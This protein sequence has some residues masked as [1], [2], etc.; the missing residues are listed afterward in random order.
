MHL[1][2]TIEDLLRNPECPNGILLDAISDLVP[3]WPEEENPMATVF[4]VMGGTGEY[5]DHRSWEVA[6]FLDEAKADALRDE[7]EAWCRANECWQQKPPWLYEK[8][9]KPPQDPQFQC[10]YTGVSYGVAAI[11]LRG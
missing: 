9:L 2:R 11:T 3:G 1:P 5:S 8:D 6:A 10:D 4:V 7:L